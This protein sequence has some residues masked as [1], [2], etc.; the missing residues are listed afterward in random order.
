[1]KILNKILLLIMVVSFAACNSDD[2][3]NNANVD[4]DGDG[5]IDSEDLCP[6]IPG[7]LLDDGCYYVSVVNLTGTHTLDFIESTRIETHM[8][9]AS[10]IVATIT[11]VGSVLQ[12]V[13][14]FNADGT[15]TITGEYLNTQ[16]TV[17]P[18][19]ED[20]IDEE[21][22]TLNESGTYEANNNNL[23]I[24]LTNN[25]TGETEVFNVTLFNQNELNVTSMDSGD[26]DINATFEE[27]QEIRLI[28]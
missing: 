20:E 13:L 8:I 27:T 28:R 1:M 2:D 21:I 4:T 14:K 22:I 16:T 24:L 23:E 15:Y 19:V 3:N 12:A 18:G 25:L 6:T 7:T 11:N 9:G 17:I 5:I 26:I 10:E